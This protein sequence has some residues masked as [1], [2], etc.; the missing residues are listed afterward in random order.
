MRVPFAPRN[1]VIPIV[2]AESLIPAGLYCYTVVP[3][4]NLEASDSTLRI[5]P[6]PYWS[7]NR[8]ARAAHGT[9]SSGY[10]SYL[11]TGDWMENGTLLLWDQVKEC[12]LKDADFD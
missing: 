10:C 7:I 12:G 5:R 2:T 4:D 8:E 1:R 3:S 6:C 9:Q 11:R